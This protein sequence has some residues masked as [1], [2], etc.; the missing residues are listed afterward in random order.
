LRFFHYEYV[1]FPPILQGK[2]KTLT[3][4][5]KMIS[6]EDSRCFFEVCRETIFITTPQGNF[7]YVNPAGVE[8]FGYAS[9]QEMLGLDIGADIYA[10]PEE[11][12]RFGKEIGERGFVKDYQLELK[13]KDGGRMM[14]LVTATA[15]MDE[16]GE[17]VEYQ[18]LHRDITLREREKEMLRAD[19]DRL[20]L[21]LRIAG[22][23]GWDWDIAS[24]RIDF[25]GQS[26]C[27]LG[28]D[29]AAFRGTREEFYGAVHPDD[30]EEIRSRLYRYVNREEEA[31]KAEYR[32]IW[33]DGSVH[34]IIGNGS[35]LRDESGRALKLHGVQMDVTEQRQ[36]EQALN[37]RKERF[38]RMVLNNYDA[39]VLLDG[40]G[41]ITFASD[42][43][44]RI[45]G[46]RPDE[47]I[48]KSVFEFIHPDDQEGLMKI[49]NKGVPQ[50]GLVATF[51]ARHRHKSGR[52]ITLES[53][54]SNLLHDPL[55][56]AVVINSRD[57]TERNRL[58]EQLRQA[59]KMEAIGR[60]AGG[61]A[62]DFNNI[63]TVITGNIEL[64]RMDVNPEDPLAPH[65]DNI[66][67]ASESAA[68]LTRRLLAFS[69]K[70]IIE[71]RVLN[72]NDLVRNI[73]HMLGRL[74]GED[75]RLSFALA[76]HLGSVRLD[77]GQF[78]QVLVNLAVNAR[79]AMP[80]GGRLAIETSNEHISTPRD[81]IS[82][83]LR[84]GRY[85]TLAVSDTGYGISADNREYI[86][87]PFFTTKGKG[88]GT[89]L[90]L[91]TI[92][93][94]VQQAGGVI[95]CQSEEGRGTTF[96]IYLPLV[97]EQAERLVKERRSV[98]RLR[99]NETVLLVE[100][101]APVREVAIMML[102]DLG[103]KTIVACSGEEAL[104]LAQ[105][106]DEHIHLLMTD[107]VMPGMNGRE[108]SER[109]SLLRPDMKTLFCSGYT[110]DVIVRN[111]VIDKSINF[112]GK[113][114]SMQRLA[115][116]IREVLGTKK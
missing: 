15:V 98:A 29:P 9:P 24:G 110:E 91:P 6:V 59:L 84:P 74:I 85:V 23:G 100:D 62:H 8:L 36:V 33:P 109:L 25:D 83:E 1:V 14:S 64:A 3:G 106:H 115:G 56:K 45:T 108:L 21:A 37:E 54:A 107:I 86:F 2:D 105:E 18:G 52:W 82:S 55:L 48:G 10:D 67:K 19:R 80:H 61:I 12:R 66:M 34:Y 65:L 71:P 116:K 51:E 114:Y 78:E 79:D 92:L 89:G 50:P 104:S 53:I 102:Q 113:P 43:E 5:D 39:I 94:I 26:C 111:G 28:L 7:R 58:Q 17:V 103:Y 69:R 97:E 4:A 44:E 101:D 20:D 47:I 13:K 75:I 30:R 73:R 72:L 38:R 63:L 90:G 42:S 41:I 96:R 95:E 70:Q 112:I 31:Y 27:M 87:E 22:I 81:A 77:S 11:R 76:D 68:S 49:Y 32:V 57:V 88:Q 40:D 60:L 46:Y 93:G 35:A 16:R 99:G